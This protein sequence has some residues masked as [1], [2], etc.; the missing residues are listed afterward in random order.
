MNKQASIFMNNI[1]Q[2]LLICLAIFCLQIPAAQS[3]ELGG[4]KIPEE[5]FIVFILIGHSN[6]IGRNN[7]CDAEPH[8]RAWN[9][10]IDDDTDAWVPATGPLFYDGQGKKDFGT[11]V[12]CGPGMP[13]LKRLVKEFPDH[14]FGVIEFAWSGGQVKHFKR[15]GKFYKKLV[16]HLQNIKSDVTFGGI[17]AMLGRMER[18][19][20]RGFA[21]E[22]AEMVSDLRE[23]VEMPT[24]PYFQ[25]LE[26]GYDDAAKKIRWQQEKVARI[27]PYAAVVKTDGP[28]HH[29]GHYSGLAET[30]WANEV[31]DILLAKEWLALSHSGVV[32]K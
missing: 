13:L 18:Y 19:E 25:Q 4:K 26:R 23:V 8:P 2:P 21:D 3:I 22:V 17:L 20:P 16:P 7:D 1:F 28:D 5:K 24:L 27:V 11:F 6:M 14:H 29:K 10:K 30:R 9:Y 15:E 32:N 31:V 12:G